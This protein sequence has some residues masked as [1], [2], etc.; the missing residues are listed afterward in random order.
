MTLQGVRKQERAGGGKV[1]REIKKNIL[2]SLS[3]VNS[4]KPVEKGTEGGKCIVKQ[5]SMIYHSMNW[6]KRYNVFIGNQTTQP[7][8]GASLGGGN[9]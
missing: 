8:W 7:E 4:Q 1:V 9:R 6:L 2:R 5:E 3:I